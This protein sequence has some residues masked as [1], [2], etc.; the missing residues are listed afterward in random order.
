MTG[1][2]ELRYFVHSVIVRARSK[3]SALLVALVY[4]D[5]TK[6]NLD[7]RSFGKGRVQERIFVA[8][9]TLATKVRR[10]HAQVTDPEL[11][12]SQYV[13]DSSFRNRQ[14]SCITRIFTAREVGSAEL[15]LLH[16]L[17]WDLSITE[18]E[19]LRSWTAVIQYTTG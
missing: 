16:V 2:P 18:D 14:W 12:S 11:T 6:L 1:N 19:V 4:L 10:G 13:D 5:R 3:I 8:A 7:P 15:A 9:L 17:K